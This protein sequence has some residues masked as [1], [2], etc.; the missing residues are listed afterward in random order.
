MH[1]YLYARHITIYPGKL[2]N[3][4]TFRIA[5][6]GALVPADI[7]CFADVLGEYL[8]ALRG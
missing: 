2:G 3:Q 7:E 4:S 5:N 6:I 8:R 1:D